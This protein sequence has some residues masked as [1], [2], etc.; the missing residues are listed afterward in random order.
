MTLND[1][2]DHHEVE[3]AD[4]DISVQNVDH[5]ERNEELFDQLPKNHTVIT[6]HLVLVNINKFNLLISTKITHLD[7]GMRRP[8]PPTTKL[9][10]SRTE[11]ELSHTAD[12]SLSNAL[13]SDVAVCDTK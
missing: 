7:L 10:E 12:G 11:S 1:K 6:D 5:Q 2:R 9:H 3:E 8:H 4:V 13:L